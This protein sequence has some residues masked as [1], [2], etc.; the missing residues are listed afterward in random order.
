MNTGNKG[1]G[2]KLNDREIAKYDACVFVN[3]RVDR[4]EGI[5]RWLHSGFLWITWSRGRVCSRGFSKKEGERRE[6]SVLDKGVNSPRQLSDNSSVAQKVYDLGSCHLSSNL[7]AAFKTS[8]FHGT[9]TES[10]IIIGSLSRYTTLKYNT[11][12]V[13]N[14]KGKSFNLRGMHR[15]ISQHLP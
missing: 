7:I 8:F 1:T 4:G 14:T 12:T 6:K 9:I 5:S 2:E 3:G 11:A 13:V 10:Y 15:V